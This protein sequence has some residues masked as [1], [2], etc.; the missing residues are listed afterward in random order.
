[1]QIILL[2]IAILMWLFLIVDSLSFLAR[3][4]KGTMVSYEDEVNSVMMCLISLSISSRI[5]K[6]QMEDNFLIVVITAI[7]FI[8]LIWRAITVYRSFR[9][10][11]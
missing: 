1:M 4:N 11:F 3:Y 2:I 7:F 5:I 10:R 8:L 9:P 6:S